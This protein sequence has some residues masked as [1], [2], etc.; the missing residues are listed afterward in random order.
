MS[1]SGGGVLADSTFWIDCLDPREPVAH[2]RARVVLDQARRGRW[3]MPFPILY[4]VLRTRL[5]RRPRQMAELTRMLRSLSI[6]LVDD[7]PFRDAALRKSLEVYPRQGRSISLVD[8]VLREIIQGRQ[9]RIRWFVTSNP[10]DFEDV[11]RIA[12]LEIVNPH[13]ER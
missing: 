8:A 6:E 13:E 10:G 3:L 2:T 5:T 4:E 12:R 7:A 1:S 11:C 9:F